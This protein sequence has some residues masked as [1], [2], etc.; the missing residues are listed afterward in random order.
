M[1]VKT[2]SCAT[3]DHCLDITVCIVPGRIMTQRTITC[4]QVIN[5]AG[6]IPGICKGTVTTG[7]VTA[8]AVGL[9]STHA[10][11]MNRRRMR[12]MRS[13][14]VVT[15]RTLARTT[16]GVTY[17]TAEQCTSCRRMTGGTT[18][19][20][21]RACCMNLAGAFKWT[22]RRCMTAGGQA[23]QGVRIGGVRRCIYC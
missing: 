5:T 22:R 3:L 18:A 11:C 10:H 6:T 8:V 16:R 19:G 1:T 17:T 20:C 4:M 12:Q 2:G 9:I 21:I 15:V 14:G 13:K 7:G 23:V